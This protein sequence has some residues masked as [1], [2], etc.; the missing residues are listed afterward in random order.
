[1]FP[2]H[3]MLPPYLKKSTLCDI[4]KHFKSMLLVT[5]I[6]SKTFYFPNLNVKLKC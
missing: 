4:Q 1:M 3:Y 2:T 6:L 5:A